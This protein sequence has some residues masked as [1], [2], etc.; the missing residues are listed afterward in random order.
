[1]PRPKLD[2][3]PFSLQTIISTDCHAGLSAKI[4]ELGY[5]YAGKP[6]FGKFLEAIYSGELEVSKKKAKKKIKKPIDE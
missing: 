3:T 6:A 5:I 1:M 2:R 4:T